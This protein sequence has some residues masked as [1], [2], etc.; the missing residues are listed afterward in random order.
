MKKPEECAERK[1]T[2][3]TVLKIDFLFVFQEAHFFRSS[4]K[5]CQSS[6]DNARIFSPRE[7]GK[8]EGD[9]ERK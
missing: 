6:G 8:E 9:G 3:C 2:K 1:Q 7:K 5:K 4:L